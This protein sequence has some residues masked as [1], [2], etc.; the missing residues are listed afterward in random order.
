MCSINKI[1]NL[2]E[3]YSGISVEDPNIDIY[4]ELD[5]TGDDFHEMIDKYSKKY[6]VDM[7]NY[8]WYFHA[9]E[10]GSSIG[11][12]FFKPPYKRIKR[13]S[14]TPQMLVDFI[15]T[16]KW[17]VEYPK[18]KIPKRRNDIRVNLILLVLFLIAIATWLVVRY[19]A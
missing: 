18:H 16:K 3:D 15:K 19:I 1:R 8:L 5:I 4:K 2:L 10:E 14:V 13:I 17:E 12:L 11:S 7:S 9:N 6:K